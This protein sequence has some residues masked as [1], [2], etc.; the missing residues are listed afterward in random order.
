MLGAFV[1]LQCA[2]GQMLRHTMDY[3]R[4]CDGCGVTSSAVETLV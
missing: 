2:L 1:C 3:R 4:P